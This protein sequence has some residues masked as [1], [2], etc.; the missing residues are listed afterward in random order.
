[1]P[2]G[3]NYGKL[4]SNDFNPNHLVVAEETKEE[5]NQQGQNIFASLVL[6]P[7]LSGLA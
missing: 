3:V 7:S 2:E 6:Y 1:M 4:H 5:G